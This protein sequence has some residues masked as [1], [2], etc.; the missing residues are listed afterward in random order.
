MG[1]SSPHSSLQL[2]SV[3]DH[4]LAR[5]GIEKLAGG[6]AFV[7]TTGIGQPRT[8]GFHAHTAPGGLCGGARGGRSHA[9]RGAC[10]TA[11]GWLAGAWSRANALIEQRVPDRRPRRWCCLDDTS[12]RH[13]HGLRRACGPTCGAQGGTAA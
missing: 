4:A 6:Y 9:R 8:W 7:L 13:R 3:R 2:A 12:A 11:S 1:A 10:G 5:H